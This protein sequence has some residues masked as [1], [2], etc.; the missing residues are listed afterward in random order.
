MNVYQ[1]KGREMDEAILVH[2][3]DDRDEWSR[4]GMARL[5]RVHYVSLSRARRG[6]TIML[7]PEP[8]SFF[9]PYVGI[10]NV[11]IARTGV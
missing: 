10:C 5:R 8:K 4:D 7:P 1:V 9:A 11:T 6:A 3:G 2:L